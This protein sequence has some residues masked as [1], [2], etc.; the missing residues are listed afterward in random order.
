MGFSAQAI[1]AGPLELLRID[2]ACMQTSPSMHRRESRASRT[3]Q[4]PLKWHIPAGELHAG[5]QPRFPDQPTLFE[6]GIPTAPRRR[7]WSS[8]PTSKAEPADQQTWYSRAWHDDHALTLAD[9]RTGF[10]SLLFSMASITTSIPRP[11][12]EA[13][14]PIQAFGTSQASATQRYKLG[15]HPTWHMTRR[16]CPTTDALAVARIAGLIA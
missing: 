15:P 14:K 11:R 7:A 13:K 10:T 9:S 16:N 6:R 4:A 3:A 5:P 12:R 2:H 1:Q 8:I